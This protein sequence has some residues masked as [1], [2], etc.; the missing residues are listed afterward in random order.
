MSAQFAHESPT[1]DF[2]PSYKELMLGAGSSKQRKVYDQG[3]ESESFK[4]LVTVDIEASHNT[5]VV[6]DLN[7]TPWPFADNEFNEI[8]AYEVLEHLGQQGD[9]KAFFAH[10]SEVWRI[11]KP[12]GRLFATV[13]MWDSPWAWGDP[14]HTRVITKQTLV[15]LVQE[16]YEAQVGKTAMADYRSVY[17]GN[18]IIRGAQEARDTLAFVLEAV[19]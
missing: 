18:F 19:K 15:F 5:D 6:H 3:G 9:Y 14:G 16:E 12:G 2:I 8:H 7:V 10:F 13:P 4:N 17:K 1:V 11:L